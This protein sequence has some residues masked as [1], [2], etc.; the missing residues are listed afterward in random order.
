MRSSAAGRAAGRTS[1][2]GGWHVFQR[3]GRPGQSSRTS[4]H[5]ARVEVTLGEPLTIAGRDYSASVGAARN[6]GDDRLDVYLNTGGPTRPLPLTCPRT[7][8][9]GSPSTSSPQWG[10]TTDAEPHRLRRRSQVGSR[11]RHPHRQGRPHRRPV[12]GPSRRARPVR[13][14]TPGTRTRLPLG[15]NPVRSRL[16]HRTTPPGHGDLESILGDSQ[17]TGMG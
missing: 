3:H 7:M 6:F 2:S 1:A 9:A 4:R 15:R 11:P 13:R 14:T 16:A 10:L 12:R 8:P 5:P 17:E